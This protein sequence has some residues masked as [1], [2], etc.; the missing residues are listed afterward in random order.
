MTKPSRLRPVV[1]ADAGW[2]AWFA[3]TVPGLWIRFSADG[4]Y[5][6]AGGSLCEDVA[7]A[8]DLV[9]KHLSDALPSDVAASMCEGIAGAIRSGRARIEYRVV[10]DGAERVFDVVIVASATGDATAFV[11]DV[12]AERA[13]AD[14][15]QR[16]RSV[17]ERTNEGIWLIAADGLTTHVSASMAAILGCVPEDMLGRSPRD[18]MDEASS[19]RFVFAEQQPGRPGGDTEGGVFTPRSVDGR[20]IPTTLAASPLYDERGRYL[21]AVARVSADTAQLEAERELDESRRR[22]GAMVEAHDDVFYVG[23]IAADGTYTEHYSGPGA[24]RLLGGEPPPDTTVEEFWEQSIHDEDRA[25][26]AAMN[27][28]LTGGEPVDLEYRVVGRDGQIRWVHDRARPRGRE[29]DRVVFDGVLSDITARRET[30]DA[31][32]AALT[33]LQVAHAEVSAAHAASNRLARTDPLTGLFNRRHF[34]DSLSAELARNQRGA[35]PPAVILIDIDHFKRINDT[36]G[37][38]CGDRVLSEIATRLA[39]AIRPYDVLARW[40]GEEFIVLTPGLP[41]AALERVGEKLLASIRSTPIST[42]AA[43]LEI[44]ASAGAARR[45]RSDTTG[46]ALIASADR[47]LYVAKRRGRDRVVLEHSIG[48]DEVASIEPETIQL[49]EGLAMAVSVRQGEPPSHSQQVADLAA[50]TA[51][52][53]GLGE[54]VVLRCRLSGWLHDVGK[55]AL[56]DHIL[57]PSADLDN[58]ERQAL[59]RHPEVGAAIVAG[60]ASLADAAPG[61]RHHHERYDG[62]GYPDGLRQ[63][64]IPLEARIVAAADTYATLTS[65]RHHQPALGHHKAL[66]RLQAACGQSLDPTIV[67]A[68]IRSLSTRFH[69]Q[70]NQAPPDASIAA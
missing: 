37:H 30:A 27:E 53:L 9:G 34:T 50:M 39:S 44:T 62:T 55:L 59:R 20:D 31:L 10:R 16:F 69:T 61:V 42:P 35:K 29:D 49:A 33:S 38:D 41:D 1:P 46:D 4:R 66:T 13:L 58:E 21:G 56:P 5:L 7:R 68:L 22:L 12:T 8:N 60:I 36:Y 11:R 52:A 28:R 45:A 23:E 67:A 32:Q 15:E 6:A 57:A 40:G 54:H 43:T 26:Y 65:S 24:D 19:A 63:D 48:A 18:F 3:A 70:P 14:S 2:L 51:S 25:A 17:L 64:A 47:A